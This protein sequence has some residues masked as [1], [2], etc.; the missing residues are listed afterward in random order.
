MKKKDTLFDAP[1]IAVLIATSSPIMMNI[2]KFDFYQFIPI[3]FFLAVIFFN[4]NSIS[5]VKVGISLIFFIL[6]LLVVIIYPLLTIRG[7]GSGGSLIVVF[8]SVFF[9]LIFRISN[10]EELANKLYKQISIIYLIHLLF[11]FIELAIVLAGQQNF[12][13]EKFSNSEV[14]LYK[15]Y[16]HAYF[17]HYLGF[18]EARGLNSLIM[19]SQAAAQLSVLIFFWFAP[20]YKYSP[21]KLRF[22]IVLMSALMIPLSSQMTSVLLLLIGIIYFIYFLPFSKIGTKF[23]K[24]I[25]VIILFTFPGVIYSLVLFKLQDIKNIPLYLD[26]FMEPVYFFYNQ[27]LGDMLWGYGSTGFWRYAANN[28]GPATDF[29]Y[30]GIVLQSGVLF[31]GLLSLTFGIII[32]MHLIV[33][34]K[35]KIIK[36]SNKSNINY[37]KKWTTFASMNAISALIWFLSLIHYV[38][39]IQ[40]GGRELF[41]L[42][43]AALLIS[44]YNIRKLKNQKFVN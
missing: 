33:F 4:F 29:G 25:G 1:F 14:I 11:L 42:H 24:S 27:N 22:F 36:I 19:G 6:A 15:N 10:S 16:N 44:I 39:A 21:F 9:Y 37:V 2:L 34:K 3:F 5:K 28:Q 8:L 17:L 38:P 7:I 41:A 43:I 40:V 31:V 35:N 30:M 26:R 23:Y 12:L 20:L 32:L 13:V 18:T